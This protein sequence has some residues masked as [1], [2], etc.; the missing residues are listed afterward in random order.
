MGYR[1]LV[2]PKTVTVYEDMWGMGTLRGAGG[3]CCLGFAAAAQCDVGNLFVGYPSGAGFAPGWLVTRK[4]MSTQFA[5]VAAS[6]NDGLD[7]R[8]ER[9]KQ[10]REHFKKAGIKLIFRKTAPKGYREKQE[11]LAG[12]PIGSNA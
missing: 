8:E 6:I 4:R 3:M 11:R 7:T 10:L 2:K 1:R 5:R 9:K 12:F